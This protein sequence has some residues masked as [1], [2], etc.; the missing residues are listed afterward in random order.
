MSDRNNNNNKSQVNKENTNK[1]LQ[2]YIHNIRNLIPL[3]RVMIENIQNMNNEDKMSIIIT[4]DN[5]L[6]EYKKIVNEW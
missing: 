6:Q 2:K 3:D 1:L 5:V 4:Q